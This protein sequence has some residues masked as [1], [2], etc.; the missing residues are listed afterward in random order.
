MGGTIK[1]RKV[2]GMGGII[3]G[4]MLGALIVLIHIAML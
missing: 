3:G 2:A 4:I 1:D